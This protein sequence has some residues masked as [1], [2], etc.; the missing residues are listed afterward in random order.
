MTSTGQAFLSVANRILRSMFLALAIVCSP[1][2]FGLQAAWAQTFSVLHNFTG[3]TDG[4]KPYAG[5][6]VGPSGEVLYGTAAEGGSGNS[7][8]VFKLTPH[9]SSWTFSPL[10]EL[11]GAADGAYPFGPVVIGPN[12]ALYGTTTEGGSESA[13]AV[14]ELRPPATFCRTILC[15]WTATVLYS[16]TG[17][18]DGEYPS[19]VSLA[20]DRAGNIYGTTFQG[21]AFGYGL[22]FE[23]SPSGGGYTESILHNFGGTDGSEPYSGVVLDAAGNVYGTT[24]YGGTGTECVNNCGTVYQLMPSDGGWIENVL[25]NFNKADGD[26]PFGNLIIDGSGNLY[27]VTA[28]GAQNGD[29]GVVYKLAPSE[30]GFNY[31]ALYT[32]SSELCSSQGGVAMDPAGNFL[33]CVFMAASMETAG[34]S[35]LLIAAKCAWHMIST[36]SVAV[37]ERTLWAPR[38]STRTAISMARRNTEVLGPAAP[39]TAARCGRSRG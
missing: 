4:A 19:N 2:S 30:G 38:C 8:T 27:G 23:L 37:T 32:F 24:L 39:S 6:T 13:G 26:Y 12:G 22:T 11:T 15:Y 29:G 17:T 10:Y 21:G 36:T 16:F 34:Y 35:S 25:V 7:G 28:D 1:T 5:L 31:S 3:G 33:G 9:N 20:F 14:F 18:P